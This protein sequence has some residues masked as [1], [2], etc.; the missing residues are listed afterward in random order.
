MHL[1]TLTL[2]AA[3]AILLTACGSGPSESDFKSA[4][5]LQMKEKTDEM[6]A[7]AAFLGGKDS[8][9][10]KMVQ[11]TVD[12]MRKVN[13]TDVHKVGCKEDGENAFICDFQYVAESGGNKKSDAVHA[14]LI[15]GVN[16]WRLE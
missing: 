3:S 1:R 4:V 10:Y 13:I 11:K 16:G 15:K 12:A 7:N 8:M 5:D 6:L 14:R 2:I 9:G